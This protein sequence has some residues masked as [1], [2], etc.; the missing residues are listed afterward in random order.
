VSVDTQLR[1]GDIGQVVALHARAYAQLA[2]FGV[3]FEALVAGD[4]GNVVGCIAD[5]SDDPRS[6]RLRWLLLPPASEATAPIRARRGYRGVR[7]TGARLGGH[8]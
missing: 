4:L 8:R 7:R 6:A 3:A 5:R 1:P 2:G